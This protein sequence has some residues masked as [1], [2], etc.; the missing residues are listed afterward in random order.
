MEDNTIANELLIKAQQEQTLRLHKNL[1]RHLNRN[2]S[3][4]VPKFKC[5]SCDP[6]DCIPQPPCIDAYQ[7][8]ILI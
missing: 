7:V 3:H 2:E 8:F 6:P 1:I 4:E 5:L